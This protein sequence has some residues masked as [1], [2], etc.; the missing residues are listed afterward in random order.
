MLYGIL[1]VND[2]DHC[3]AEAKQSKHVI[4]QN[5]RPA[6]RH[7]GRRSVERNIAILTYRHPIPRT[8]VLHLRR[9]KIVLNTAWQI[10]RIPRRL[11]GPHSQRRLSQAQLLRRL[12]RRRKLPH[13]R[14]H[15]RRATALLRRMVH[16]LHHRLRHVCQDRRTG[17][18]RA[19]TARMHIHPRPSRRDTITRRIMNED[20][21]AGQD[22][23]CKPCRACPQTGC[24]RH[25]NQKRMTADQSGH[26]VTNRR[27]SL[28]DLEPLLQD[29]SLL[30]HFVNAPSTAPPSLTATLPPLR[31]ALSNNIAQ[32]NHALKLAAELETQRQQVT[33]Q[34]LSVRALERQ[35]RNKQSETET[36]LARFGPRELHQ[37][38]GQSIVEAE[39]DCEWHRGRA[40]LRERGKA[41]ERETQEWIKRVKD[42]RGVVWMRKERRARW[43]EG[44]VGGWR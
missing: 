27:H 14:R 13:I 21:M 4:H 29:K 18:V 32:A 26:H 39:G 23:N 1:A 8:P 38:L 33:A 41:S 30:S 24:R 37:R 31:Q 28:T 42:A 20:M 40:G 17:R 11:I 36:A 3:G 44:R 5:D 43:D 12:L 25:S 7:A 22:T 19:S 35:W 6:V 34:L 10:T 15:L 16:R 9:H 2:E